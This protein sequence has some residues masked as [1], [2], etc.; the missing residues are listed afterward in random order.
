[1]LLAA[2][3][4]ASRLA[5]FVPQRISECTVVYLSVVHS[6]ARF[7]FGFATA[8][9]PVPVFFF[10][11][12]PLLESAESGHRKIPRLPVHYR[13]FTTIVTEAQFN[14]TAHI[15]ERGAGHTALQFGDPTP[16]RQLRGRPRQAPERAADLASL[17]WFAVTAT[18][19]TSFF[20]AACCIESTW[21]FCSC[22]LW[23]STR[24]N[25]SSDFPL[26]DKFDLQPGS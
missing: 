8:T 20:L 12:Q 5:E 21:R 18:N 23:R 17:R 15:R 13:D 14:A 9:E 19:Q 10:S 24:R 6:P 22:R 7:R 1:L 3:T 11:G 4:L 26:R 2:A 25:S 16:V